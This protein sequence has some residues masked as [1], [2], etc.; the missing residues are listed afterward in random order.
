MKEVHEIVFNLF[1]SSILFPL[2]LFLFVSNFSHESL[3]NHFN[4]SCLQFLIP[5]VSRQDL[6]EFFERRLQTD[7]PVT[8]FH[9]VSNDFLVIFVTTSQVVDIE[10]EQV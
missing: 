5:V 9:D 6:E 10:L 2:F 3:E 4:I 7:L 8:L 1:P